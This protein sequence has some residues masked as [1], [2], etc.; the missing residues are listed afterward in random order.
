MGCPMPPFASSEDQPPSKRGRKEL[1]EQMVAFQATVD[2]FL[3]SEVSQ[4]TVAEFIQSMK[5]NLGEGSE[6]YS[7]RH[8]KRLLESML[9]DEVRIDHGLITLKGRVNLKTFIVDSMDDIE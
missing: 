4:L 8:C 2:D 3:D 6:P 5:N 7:H 1:D 9:G